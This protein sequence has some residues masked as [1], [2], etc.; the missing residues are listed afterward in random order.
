MEVIDN[1]SEA[2]TKLVHCSSD[3]EFFYNS[4]GGDPSIDG[5]WQWTIPLLEFWPH[6]QAITECVLVRI[7]Q[8]III[9]NTLNG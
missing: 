4:K 8:R 7:V 3:E 2:N 9:I 5:N 6:L 1:L